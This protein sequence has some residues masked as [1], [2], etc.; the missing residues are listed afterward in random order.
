M[1]KVWERPITEVQKFEANEYVAA[2][3][4][5][6]RVYKFICDAP[7]GELYYYPTSD[8]NI[9]GI[10]TGTGSATCL[11]SGLLSSYSPCKKTHEASTTDEFYDGF[12][13][14]NYNR[15]YDLGEEVI[16]WR[17]P[18]GNNGHATKQLNMKEW[19]TAKS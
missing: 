4:D 2:C 17:G 15:R 5:Q 8:G 13:D 14:Y 11:T 19:E 9:D 3:G 1:N 12:V 6:N 18:K 16:V 7:G 10:Y